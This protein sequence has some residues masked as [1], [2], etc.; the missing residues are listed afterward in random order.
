M[1]NNEIE[2]LITLT[3][4]RFYEL[5]EEQY[6]KSVGKILRYHDIDC[7]SILS[8]IDK[9]ALIDLFEKPNDEHSTSELIDL[10]KEICNI[11]HESIS[12]KI[13]TKN[14]II[15]LL[16]S[17]QEIVKKRRLQLVY[18]ARLNRLDKRRSTSSSSTNNSASDSENNL[19]KYHALLEESII[20]LLRQLKNNIHGTTY[21]NVSANDFKV[22]IGNTSDFI[23][24][25]C[26]V[27]CIC[28]DRIKLYLKNYRFQ[29]SNLTK[30]LKTINHKSPLI[31]NNKNHDLGDPEV[32]DQ[33]DSDDPILRSEND[34]STTQNNLSERVHIDNDDS[35][36]ST[37]VTIKKSQS[38]KSRT[39]S[40][41]NKNIGLSAKTTKNRYD[42][43]PSTHTLPREGETQSS[44]SFI[45]SLKPKK[46]LVN[47]QRQ[48]TSNLP[49]NNQHLKSLREQNLNQNNSSQSQKRKFDENEKQNEAPLSKKLNKIISEKNISCSNINSSDI[50]SALLSTIELNSHRSPNNFRYS[51]PSLRF[52]ACLFIVSG[53]YVYEYLRINFKFLLPSIETVKNYY[54]HN[55]FSEAEFRY[56]ESKMYLDSIQCQFV[57]LSEDCSAIIP[58]VEYDSTLNSFNGF[59]TPIADGKPVENAFNCQ[60]FEE[61]KHLIE[62]KPRAN[63]VNVHLLQPI[64]DSNL[65][66]TPSATVLSAYGT[67]NKITAIDILKRWLMIYQELHSRNIRVLGFST[68]GDPKYLRAMRLASN[69]FVKTQTLNIYNDKLSF[70]VKI[71]SAWSSWYFFSPTQLFL[72]MQDG[73]HL[74]TKIR[75]RLLSP[76]AQLKMG[77]FTVSVKHLYQLIKTKNKIDHNLSKSDIN[78]R[79]KQNFSSC[80]KI[81]DDKVLNLLLL[82]DHYKATFNYLLI[83][84]LLIVAYTQTKVCLSTRI[85][86]AWI[87]LFFIRLWRIWLYKTKKKRKASTGNKK[88]NEQSYF[89]TSNALMS[90]ELNAHCLIYVYLL[91]EQKL[92]PASTANCI[93]LFSSQPCENVFRDARAL[94]GIYTTRINFTMKQFLQRINKLNALT[95]LRQFESTNTHERITFPVHHKIK[96]LTHETESSNMDEDGDFNSDNVETIIHRAYEVAQQMVVFVG[97]SKDLIKYN[98]FNIEESSHMAQTLFNLNILTESEILVLDGRDTEDSDEEGGFNEYEE[99]DNDDDEEDCTEDDDEE[100]G[101]EDEE[102]EDLT[103]NDDE[104]DGFEKDDH[105]EDG[106]VEDCIDED[107]VEEINENVYDY[108]S[109]EDDPQP[110]PSFENLESTSYSGLRLIQSVSRTNAHKYFSIN[111]HKKKM[112]LHKA[113]ATWYLQDRQTHL[114]SDRLQRV[115]LKKD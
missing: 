63:L 2:Q 104:E 46:Q 15:L 50:L 100:D 71:P 90:I 18:E 70:T 108:C 68:D 28:G 8:Q 89:I 53:V 113:T 49:F 19:G 3:G 115:Q 52:A 83:L 109:S 13:G 1:D 76:N 48:Q 60:S 40:G 32:L 64:S 38:Q 85:Y 6:G 42:E 41:N 34:R 29:L 25:V 24:P 11:S 81:S 5:I 27:Q 114:S 86:Y 101:T 16:K 103:E 93:H 59:V 73:I 56:D 30:H 54:N 74:C 99:E 47:T 12:L 96:R 45:P 26:S 31:V 77:I 10:K 37:S 105:A 57:F 75:N 106:D 87:V 98:L 67:D 91:I 69:F 84:N 107:V 22:I 62:T 43:Q 72:F 17:S 55:P 95:E 14:K 33:T 36:K 112:F 110:T 61:F 51:N 82:N 4:E 9:H 58:R 65:Y 78:V 111:I 66:V 39:Q 92:V 94:S 102:E 80:Q 97:M 44:I 79:D 35:D 88:R 7:Y 21:T 20:Q 23:T